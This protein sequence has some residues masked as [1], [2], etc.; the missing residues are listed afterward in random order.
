[1]TTGH[2][3]PPER[4][5]PLAQHYRDA[6][7]AAGHTAAANLAVH[8]HCVVAEDRAEAWRL[9]EAGLH[10]HNRLNH[11]TRSL[12][13]ANPGPEP[14]HPTVEQLVEQARIL[15]GTPDDCVALLRRIVS[16]TGATEAHCMFQFG[17]ITFEQAQRSLEL[18]AQEVMPRF[19]TAHD[20]QR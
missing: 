14:A 4:T 6:W 10:E 18:F 12:S 19:A 5:A 9:A 13:Q 2:S 17:S 11:E 3:R 8:Y 16:E 1:M 15:A 20:R 7:Q